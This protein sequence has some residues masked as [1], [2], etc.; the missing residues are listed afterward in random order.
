MNKDTLWLQVP[1][2]KMQPQTFISLAACD[3][4]VTEKLE[5]ITHKSATPQNNATLLKEI[6]TI[7]N[8]VVIL[9]VADHG[10]SLD[11]D[12][13]LMHPVS[14]KLLNKFSAT[15]TISRI[16]KEK[17]NAK[18]ETINLGT[19]IKPESICGVINSKIDCSSANF[20]HA[21]AMNKEQLAK[22]INIGRQTAQRIKLSGS[23]LFV[24]REINSANELSALAMACALLDINLNELTNIDAEQD[25]LIRQAL[26]RHKKNLT[27]PLEILRCLGSFEISALTGSYLCCAHMGMPVLIDG[28]ASAVAALVASRLCP[29]AEQWFLY[30][31]SANNS[32]HKRILKIL[33]AQ[34]LL[35]TNKNLDA[36]A[37]ITGIIMALSQLQLACNSQ[38]ENLNFSEDNL[39]KRYS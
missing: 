2:A 21:Q 14:K 1:A 12:I 6:T 30:S 39:L 4:D 15:N 10:I 17:I 25:R 3:D 29:G 13:D 18:L 33:K 31:T 23:Q 19:K 36:E 34:P 16:L 37:G 8:T 38:Y 32:A 28:F 7:E 27:S 20:C 22:A 5:H 35:Q 9:Y 24:A 26:I 11:N